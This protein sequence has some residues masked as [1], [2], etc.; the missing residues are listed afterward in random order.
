MT[1]DP[2][3]PAPEGI[4]SSP[5]ALSIGHARGLGYHVEGVEKTIRIPGGRTFKRDYMGVADFHFVSVTEILAV[6]ACA[7]AG[8]R[9]GDHAARKAKCLVSR[10]LAIWLAAPGRRFEI[11]SWSTRR[12]LERTKAGK[13]SKRLVH[14]LRREEIR[15]SDFVP[16]Q[17]QAVTRE[18]LT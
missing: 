7:G 17:E 11:W 8:K 9:G 18:A 14:H 12:S 15:L 2:R 3:S 6:Q 10:L 13:R 5:S 16:Q 4:V 1:H